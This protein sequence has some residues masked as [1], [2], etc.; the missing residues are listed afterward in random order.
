MSHVRI[1]VDGR[2]ITCASDVT[3]AAALVDA[4]VSAFRRSVSGDARG[5]VCG[6]GICYECRVTIDGV[7]H[8][9]A[10]LITVADGMR[11]TSGESA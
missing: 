3:V 11:V 10:C 4:G 9:R 1:V 7:A 2:E 8:R 6:M 5:P